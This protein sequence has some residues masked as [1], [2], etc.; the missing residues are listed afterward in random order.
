[1]NLEEIVNRYSIKLNRIIY[2]DSDIVSV[3]R[4]YLETNI[5]DIFNT[6]VKIFMESTF[7]TTHNG[8]TI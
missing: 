2:I 8:L 7:G 4:L 6:K 5:N 1:M 3:K